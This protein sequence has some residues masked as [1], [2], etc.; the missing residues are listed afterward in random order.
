MKKEDLLKI[1]G[2]TDAIADEVLKA[3]NGYLPKSRFDEVN[4]AKKQ[5]EKMIEDLKKS[6][7]TTDELKA[8]IEELQA[9]NK[10]AFEA[11]RQ[12]KIDNAIENALRAADARSVKTILPLL[13]DVND[14]DENGVVKG[15]DKQIEDLIKSDG[16]LFNIK[17]NNDKPTY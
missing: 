5:A 7:G 2:M 10:K 14:I 4:E 1:E 9:E 11:L 8:K 13:K 15:L 6:E 3:F 17:T 16:Y 12:T